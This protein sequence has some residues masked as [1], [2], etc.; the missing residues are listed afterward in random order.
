[1]FNKAG[2]KYNADDKRQFDIEYSYA[3]HDI[4]SI[5]I[6]I[7]LGYS[8]ESLPKDLTLTSKFGVYSIIFKVDEDNIEVIREYKRLAGRFPPSDYAEF[9]KFYNEM[10][11]ADRS[12][13]VLIKKEN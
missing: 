8:I 13:V 5:A 7:P 3:F 6:K 2:L 12:Q 9:A 10:Y 11:K 1:L 4:D